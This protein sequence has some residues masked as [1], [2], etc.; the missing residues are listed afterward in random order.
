M[1]IRE[2]TQ[3]NE[4]RYAQL[5]GPGGIVNGLRNANDIASM[6]KVMKDLVDKQEVTPIGEGFYGIAYQGKAGYAV[7]K[8]SQPHSSGATQVLK[9]FY[10]L[11]QE[12]NNA[13][14]FFPRVYLYGFK[15]DNSFWVLLENLK[16]GTE[17]RP[18]I[19]STF[20]IT[21]GVDIESSN[22]KTNSIKLSLSDVA[23]DIKDFLTQKYFPRSNYKD[24]EEMKNNNE[25]TSEQKKNFD[26]LV[27]FIKQI[28]NQKL[29]QKFNFDLHV[30]NIGV[31]K[32]GQLVFFDPVAG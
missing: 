11:C 32:N 9:S 2:I 3:L 28:I 30:K 18:L 29:E 14:P 27:D 23:E 17:N 4:L 7:L 8:I 13:N 5:V 22:W 10:K 25:R 6:N 24:I 31:R 16:V 21:K 12:K 19:I 1:R 20:G 26:L 15:T